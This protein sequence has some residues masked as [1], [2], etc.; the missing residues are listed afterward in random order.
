MIGAGELLNGARVGIRWSCSLLLH[1]KGSF[2]S[3]GLGRELRQTPH[4]A[5][6][7]TRCSFGIL[8]R[9]PRYEEVIARREA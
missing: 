7:S 8:K 4:L 6:Q 9:Y 3:F 2:R 5:C 1:L